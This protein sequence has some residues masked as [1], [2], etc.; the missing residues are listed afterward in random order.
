MSAA[1]LSIN[2]PVIS[3]SF[4]RMSEAKKKIE[5]A[6][7]EARCEADSLSRAISGLQVS[8][9]RLRMKAEALN[10]LRSRII[11]RQSS[12]QEVGAH[13]DNVSRTFREVDELCAQRISSSGHEYARGAGLSTQSGVYGYI[14]GGLNSVAGQGK[15]AWDYVKTNGNRID[16][17]ADARSAADSVTG[18][19]LNPA[20]PVLKAT[21]EFTADGRLVLRDIDS[22]YKVLNDIDWGIKN[23]ML[24]F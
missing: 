21:E 20:N 23:E 5:R 7:E 12:L 10:S 13:I 24:H 16:V 17:L 15:A 1:S 11:K 3:I 14:T 9:S 19:S 2:S 18:I 22:E 6:R 4:S 8:D